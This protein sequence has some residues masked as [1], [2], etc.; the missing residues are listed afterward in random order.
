M[1]IFNFFI[2]PELITKNLAKS[3]GMRRWLIAIGGGVISTGPIY[4]WYPLLRELKKHGVS[5]GFVAAFLYARA[6]KPFLF[7]VMI[8]YFGWK[9]AFVLTFVMIVMS[10]GQGVTI[11]RLNLKN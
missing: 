1:F 10:L 4:L 11:E 7:P 8:F 9:Y 5:D 2:T 6:I 3:S